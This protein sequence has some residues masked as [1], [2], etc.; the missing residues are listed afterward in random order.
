MCDKG[1]SGARSRT[2]MKA[3]NDL[4]TAHT[5]SGVWRLFLISLIGLAAVALFPYTALAASRNFAAGSLII[6]MDTDTTGN[7]ASFNQNLGMWKAYGLVYRLLQNGVPVYW[8]IKTF[9]TK[10]FDDI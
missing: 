9:P 5:G 4:F 6:P 2:S 8:T 3:R 1:P 7:H 10:S